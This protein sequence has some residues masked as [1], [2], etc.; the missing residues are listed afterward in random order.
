M[1]KNKRRT[2]EEKKTEEKK[3]KEE[4]CASTQKGKNSSNHHFSPHRHLEPL[5]FFHHHHQ[6]HRQV[7]LPSPPPPF[8]SS[9]SVALRYSSEQWRVFSIVFCPAQTKMVG[10]VQP[11]PIKKDLL[12]YHRSNTLLGQHRPNP[13]LGPTSSQ[14]LL[15]RSRPSRG[16]L[17]RPIPIYINYKQKKS[18]NPFKNF[19][20]F[21]QIF[22]PFFY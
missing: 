15:G 5:S 21:S 4:T 18:K 2:K 20:I 10:W 6:R 8:S 14:F 11:S 12:G 13:C 22:L 19:V 7:S 1:R 16:G 17:S 9:P 3:E